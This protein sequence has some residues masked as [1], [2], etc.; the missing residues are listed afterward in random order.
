MHAAHGLLTLSDWADRSGHMDPHLQW[1]V[2]GW[3]GPS[4]DPQM[5][6]LGGAG[7]P[8]AASADTRTTRAF[9]P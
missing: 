5:S 6:I 7:R 2:V 8:L 4:Q 9:E 1:N 3:I